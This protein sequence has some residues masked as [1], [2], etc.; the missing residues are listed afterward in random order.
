[1][2]NST[3]K[4][5]KIMIF[6]G[7]SDEEAAFYMKLIKQSSKQPKSFIF[8]MTTPTSLEWKVKDLIAELKEE[9]DYFKENNKA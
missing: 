9:H 5:P 2:N 3:E 1:M 4:E 7:L 6:H 8:A